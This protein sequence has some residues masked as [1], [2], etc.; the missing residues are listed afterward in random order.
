MKP[1]ARFIVNAFM[2]I[3]LSAIM[4]CT[5]KKDSPLY[6]TASIV[7]QPGSLIQFNNENFYSYSD[8]DYLV[9]FRSVDENNQV[10]TALE[11]TPSLDERKKGINIYKTIVP[12]GTSLSGTYIVEVVMDNYPEYKFSSF[13][14]DDEIATPSISTSL[15]W[16]AIASDPNKKLISYSKDQIKSIYKWIENY[17]PGQM[18]IFG[19]S[20][21][22]SLPQLYKFLQNGLANNIE[23]IKLLNSFG[24]SFNYDDFGKYVSG[25]ILF[26]TVKYPPLLDP[27]LTRPFPGDV[28]ISEGEKLTLQIFGRDL[29]ADMVFYSWR[30]QDADGNWKIIDTGTNLFSWTPDYGQSKSTPYK[31]QV[32]VSNGGP[33]SLWLDGNLPTWNIYVT[34]YIRAPS[35]TES[36]CELNA[37][38]R[39]EW[40]CTLKGTDP[41]GYPLKWKIIPDSSLFAYVYVNGIKI[42]DIDNSPEIMGD[43]VTVSFTPLNVDG[44][45]YPTRIIGARLFNVPDQI[46]YAKSVYKGIK[47]VIN[48]N[49]TLPDFQAMP[50]PYSNGNPVVTGYDSTNDLITTLKSQNPS[51]VVESHVNKD[52]NNYKFG[53]LRTW[54]PVCDKD[55][56]TGFAA[57]DDRIDYHFQIKVKS[58]DDVTAD[59]TATIDPKNPSDHV[60]QYQ[61]MSVDNSGLVTTNDGLSQVMSVKNPDNPSEIIDV[62]NGLYNSTDH[63]TTF[64]F[65]ISKLNTAAITGKP[66]QVK[67]CNNHSGPPPNYDPLCKTLSFGFIIE[68]RTPCVFVATTANSISTTE[69]DPPRSSGFAA[70]ST[71]GL[72]IQTSKTVTNSSQN[73]TTDKCSVG[74]DI[75]VLFKPTA[76]SVDQYDVLSDLPFILNKSSLSQISYPLNSLFFPSRSKTT[77]DFGFILGYPDYS[78]SAAAT[79]QELTMSSYA[80]VPGFAVLKSASSTPQKF[81]FNFGPAGT[82]QT[83]SS[84]P[85]P[86]NNQLK[87]EYNVSLPGTGQSKIITQY[88]TIPMYA[89]TTITTNGQRNSLCNV[90][91]ATTSAPLNSYPSTTAPRVTAN[92][93]K[94]VN[95]TSYGDSFFKNYRNMDTTL[96]IAAPLWPCFPAQDLLSNTSIEIVPLTTDVNAYGSVNFNMDYGSSYSTFPFFTYQPNE[97]GFTGTSMTNMRAIATVGNLPTSIPAGTYFIASK[98]INNN[99]KVYVEKFIFKTLNATIIP[100]GTTNFYPI[101]VQF[102]WKEMQVPSSSLSWSTDTWNF[103]ANGNNITT[104]QWTI[105]NKPF[106]PFVGWNKFDVGTKASSAK[107]SISAVATS[108]VKIEANQL[109]RFKSSQN[110]VQILASNSAPV[111]AYNVAAISGNESTITLANLTA[112][113]VTVNPNTTTLKSDNGALFNFKNS[114]TITIPANGNID[115]PVVRSSNSIDEL[116][117]A[118]TLNTVITSDSVLK[119]LTSGYPYLSAKNQNLIDGYKATVTITNDSD[120]DVTIDNTLTK[121]LST[122]GVQFAFELPGVQTQFIVP[123]RS[124]IDII[125]ARD[126]T[127]S[128]PVLQASKDFILN[129]AE[130]DINYSVTSSVSASTKPDIAIP[131]QAFSIFE[132]STTN[133]LIMNDIYEGYSFAFDLTNSLNKFPP[134]CKLVSGAFP[135]SCTAQLCLYPESLDASCTNKC[136]GS[137]IVDSRKCYLRFKPTV[138]DVAAD[139]TSYVFMLKSKGL[140][141][142]TEKAITVNISV[143]ED[144][145]VPIFAYVQGDPTLVANY[146]NST[147]WVETTKGS[148]ITDPFDTS[149][150]N[151]YSGTLTNFVGFDENTDYVSGKTN[152]YRIFGKTITKS[153]AFSSLS[154][155]IKEFWYYN[156]SS[157]LTKE[158]AI[159]AGIGLGPANTSPLAPVNM[160]CITMSGDTLTSC[161]DANYN[162]W[163]FIDINWKPT[164]EQAKKYSSNSGIIM[165]VEV[166]SA[167]SDVSNRKSFDLYLKF[168]VNNTNQDGPSFIIGS[169][170]SAYKITSADSNNVID[171]ADKTKIKVFVD[172]YVK[173]EVT[174]EDPDGTSPLGSSWATI[175][176]LCNSETLETDSHVCNIGTEFGTDYTR[177]SNYDPLY[178]GNKFLSDGVTINSLCRNSNGTLKTLLAVPYISNGTVVTP[179]AGKKRYT[180]T[181]EWCPQR[182]QLGDYSGSLVAKDFGDK[183]RN[184]TLST[185]KSKSNLLKFSVVSK[186]FFTSPKYNLQTGLANHYMRQ[187]YANMTDPMLYYMTVNNTLGNPLQFTLTSPLSPANSCTISTAAPSCTLTNGMKLTTNPLDSSGAILSWKPVTGDLSPALGSP[188]NLKIAVKDTITGYVDNVTFSLVVKDPLYANYLYDGI[189]NV[190]SYEYAPTI[191]SVTAQI[192]DYT[193]TTTTYTQTFDGTNYSYTNN[194]EVLSVIEGQDINFDVTY[195]D[196]N[197][198]DYLFVRWFV[199][200]KVIEDKD[201][202]AGEATTFKYTPD[203]RAGGAVVTYN[204]VVL[205]Q[206]YHIVKVEVTDGSLISLREWKVKVRNTNLQPLTSPAFNWVTARQNSTPTATP[207][208]LVWSQ[209][210]F[211]NY[212]PTV[213]TQNDYLVLT[214][215]YKIGTNVRYSLWSVPFINGNA[216]AATGPFNFNESFIFN[217]VP[218]RL[219][220][221]IGSNGFDVY[222]TAQ[223]N[224]FSTYAADGSNSLSASFPVDLRS[225][226]LLACASPCSDNYFGSG[227]SG[228]NLNTQLNSGSGDL[229]TKHVI[230]NS[231]TSSK[232]N[233]LY[234]TFD[235][236]RKILSLD[237]GSKYSVTDISSYLGV[238]AALDGRAIVYSP[239]DKILY[240][241]YSGSTQTLIKRIDVTNIATATPSAV[242]ATG[243]EI[244]KLS[245]VVIKNGSTDFDFKPQ[246]AVVVPVTKAGETFN[247]RLVVY[248]GKNTTGGAVLIVDPNKIGTASAYK[249]IRDS[250][251]TLAG[252]TS[253]VPGIGNRLVYDSYNQVVVG[254][255]KDGNQYFTF[256][257]YAEVVTVTAGISASIP[258]SMVASPSGLVLSIDRTNGRV[259]QF[260]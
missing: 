56:D 69:S 232:S 229:L 191:S 176:S 7:I 35:I 93:S 175:M 104:A 38:I 27:T 42:T 82:Q 258:V 255:V 96:E 12:K 184:N 167:C 187:V 223:T 241:I 141:S 208:T 98:T 250:S 16:N 121:L 125:A 62:S 34:P 213:G 63:T 71:T 146:G 195:S 124:S 198:N 72:S 112:D 194:G 135:V 204:N 65:K 168:K 193:N 89:N 202:A 113:P 155:S 15:A 83:I 228:Q 2:L 235:N 53:P 240:V 43:T 153:T 107:T 180:Y 216:P 48:D 248:L 37:F 249:I 196:P 253:D 183:D 152:S 3:V 225:S 41:T 84:T 164:D 103:T 128:T 55:P 18:E 159:P 150:Q 205:P 21:E 238:P 44:L 131:E 99:S 118:Y 106:Y 226:T 32:L 92:F 50:R 39:N 165:R 207:N 94:W 36:N 145:K 260:K 122:T 88:F 201:I 26:G 1:L 144:N 251:N 28:N 9:Y 46:E 60:D 111:T 220:Y 169:N 218:R 11:I 221:N 47:V 206:G 222:L 242:I 151:T 137:K 166:C 114:T 77:S 54:D 247:Y 189:T 252:S 85:V 74:A 192:K 91:G 214:G 163:S 199:D 13:V 139:G 75:Q 80:M 224:R 174:I 81:Y 257:P 30:T 100:S 177:I 186:P 57:T 117:L 33:F 130:S 132:A 160:S 79:R 231:S 10:K 230:V 97:L 49:A 19:V 14:F 142:A 58:L 110:L 134:S 116:V 212:S 157:V 233:H 254:L 22:T 237:K 4:S 185:S 162:S 246:G 215:S 8:K 129:Y 45:L 211:L 119:S 138:N 148:L 203:S 31:F 197:S 73:C 127:Q 52:L 236:T 178:A 161:T 67:I 245:D 101:P 188:T 86:I 239:S 217:N 182:G 20:K 95:Y 179:A 149:S 23:F 120:S 51:F 154:A 133:S 66:Y 140:A 209:E 29:N 6:E 40:K 181:I 136:D 105:D 158:S 259:Y 76:P 234:A 109:S 156:A 70:L 17:I 123:A 25:P 90:P 108:R 170:A 61:T 210:T 87:A 256:E 171:T 190:N 5:Q 172:T 78:L 59:S 173:F 102:A 147:K 126:Y 219:D 227:D 143:K 200:G 115:V 64:F 244:V 243:T 24:A 68:D